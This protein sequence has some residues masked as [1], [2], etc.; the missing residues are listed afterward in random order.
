MIKYLYFLMAATMAVIS[1]VMMYNHWIFFGIF[2]L[3]VSLAGALNF[4]DIIDNNKET[5]RER[6]IEY[7][8]KEILNKNLTKEQKQKELAQLEK[9]LIK[10]KK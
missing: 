8:R 6:R 9:E 4:I 1:G 10:L 3:I 5:E 2:M 7:A